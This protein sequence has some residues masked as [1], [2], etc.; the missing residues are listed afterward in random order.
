MGDFLLKKQE[1]QLMHS[2][3][4]LSE[5]RT[6]IQ[7]L[8]PPRR[9]S[10]PGLNFRIFEIM[11]G[12]APLSGLPVHKTGCRVTSLQLLKRSERVIFP[13]SS[14]AALSTTCP[15]FCPRGLQVPPLLYP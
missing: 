2:E 11:T 10:L 6:S 13:C 3:I 12:R 5:D 15:H 8:K 4:S 7:P 14:L 1:L 9:H